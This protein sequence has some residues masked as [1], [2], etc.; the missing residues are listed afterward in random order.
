MYYE[1]YD[2]HCG[3]Q[4]DQANAMPSPATTSA[5][6]QETDGGDNDLIE[7]ASSGW[8]SNV[9]LVKKKTGELRFCIDYRKL[10]EAT[11]K[12]A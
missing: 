12:D 9:V 11:N 3:P 8:A 5:D 10:N 6:N 1:A 4:A 7:P 2:R